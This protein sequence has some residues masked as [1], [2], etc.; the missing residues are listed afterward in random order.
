[1]KYSYTVV[2]LLPFYDNNP[3]YLFIF[4]VCYQ[5]WGGGSVDIIFLLVGEGDYSGM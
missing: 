4:F 2:V 5:G 3:V 1:M